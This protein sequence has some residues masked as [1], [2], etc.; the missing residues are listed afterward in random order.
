[1]VDQ[2]ADKI[3]AVETM[4]EI[5]KTEIRTSVRRLLRAAE[6]EKYK[7]WLEAGG[8]DRKQWNRKFREIKKNFE[9]IWCEIA[10]Y[11]ALVPS[12]NR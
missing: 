5:A 10:R 4:R 11:S 12:G 3:D 9:V 2:F 7:T 6:N 8:K 1:M